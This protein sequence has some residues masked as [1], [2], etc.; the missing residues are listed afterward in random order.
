MRKIKYLIIFIS[1][2]V[3]AHLLDESKLAQKYLEELSIEYSKLSCESLSNNPSME[4]ATC[5][6]KREII[7]DEFKVWSVKY[8]SCK[9][10][11]Y[12]RE[13]KALCS[14]IG[15]SKPSDMMRGIKDK[16]YNRA[17]NE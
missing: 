8:A 3:S 14:S 16:A 2:S 9:L 11:S 12:H 13:L 1:F 5:I 4:K 15:D 17:Y 10:G 6:K 7:K